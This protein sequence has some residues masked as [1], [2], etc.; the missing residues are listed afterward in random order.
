MFAKVMVCAEFCKGW[1]GLFVFVGQRVF[2]RDWVSK[3]LYR[4]VEAKGIGAGI[5][6]KGSKVLRPKVPQG[7]KGVGQ[8]GWMAK[9]DGG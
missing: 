4:G 9:G 3:I 1:G 8:R 7:A 2:V 5:G 6:P